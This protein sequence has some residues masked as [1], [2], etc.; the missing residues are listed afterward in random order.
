MRAHPA[1]AVLFR[2]RSGGITLD[3]QCSTP[4]RTIALAAALGVATPGLFT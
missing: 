4:R 2:A 3:R 1:A